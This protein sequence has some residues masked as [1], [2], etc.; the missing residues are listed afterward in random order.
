MSGRQPLLLLPAAGFG[1][2]AGAFAVIYAVQAAGCEFGWDRIGPAGGPSLLRV[3]LV[4]LLVLALAANGW[5]WLRLR[6]RGWDPG[7]SGFLRATGAWAAAAALFSTL[8]TF[9]GAAALTA[10]A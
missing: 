5:L 3:L 1:I 2:W 9:A 4:G 7:P 6:S 10:C 8:F